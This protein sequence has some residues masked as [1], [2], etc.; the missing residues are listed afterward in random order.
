MESVMRG[1]GRLSLVNPKD[2]AQFAHRL[3]TAA[4]GRRPAGFMAKWAKD[5]VRQFDY[6]K[7]VDRYEA[8][9]QTAIAN[10]ERSVAHEDRSDTR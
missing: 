5:Y 4:F 10:A 8:L 1:F 7:I 2:T 3:E 6:P 9:Y